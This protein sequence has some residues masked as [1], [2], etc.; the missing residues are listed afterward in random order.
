MNKQTL[1]LR[2]LLFHLSYSG[3]YEFAEK[4][5]RKRQLTMTSS[6]SEFPALRSRE[7]RDKV[8]L[9]DGRP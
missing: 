2:R 7:Q 8:A 6:F 4:K 5:E 3:R 9:H 1:T